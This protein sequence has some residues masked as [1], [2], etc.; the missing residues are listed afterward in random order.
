[1]E[2]GAGTCPTPFASN[3]MPPGSELRCDMGA[4]DGVLATGMGKTA[5]EGHGYVQIQTVVERHAE[6]LPDA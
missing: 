6:P 2:K 5:T 1:M 4:H 3:D